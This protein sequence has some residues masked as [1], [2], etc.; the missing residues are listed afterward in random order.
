M[1]INVGKNK[2]IISLRWYTIPVKLNIIHSDYSKAC[3]K[4]DEE[5]GTY[6]HI[7]RECKQIQ[8]FWKL[9]FKEICDIFGKDIEFNSKIV[10][11]SIFEKTDFDYCSKELIS[12]CMTSARILISRFWKDKII[13]N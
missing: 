2:I 5:I 4:C 9:I 11:L 8:K 13:L 1:R 12:N 3:W 10:L 7:W 6:Y